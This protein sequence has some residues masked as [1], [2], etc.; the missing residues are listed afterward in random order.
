MESNIIVKSIYRVFNGVLN[1]GV[2]KSNKNGRHSDALVYFTE[3]EITYKFNSTEITAAAESII[4]LPRGSVYEMHIKKKSK[5]ICVDFDFNGEDGSRSPELYKKLPGTVTKEFM[6]LFYNRYRSEPWCAS[7]A[8]SSVYKIYAIALRSKYKSYTKSSRKTTDA[9]KYIIENYTDPM[10]TV[11][12]I[13]KIIGIS[14]THLRRLL[15]DKLNMSPIKYITHLRI[16]KAKNMLENTNCTVSEIA[17]LSGF[18]DQYYF[19][20]EFKLNVGIAPTDYKRQSQ[21]NRL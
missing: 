4:Y 21:K 17:S 14:E 15:K 18:S 10:I 12:E 7:E 3:G 9:I 6:K 13:S 5:Y 11:A 8:F 2:L 16:E 1:V 20:R 19:S